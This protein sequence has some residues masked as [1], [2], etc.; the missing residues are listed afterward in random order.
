[1]MSTLRKYKYLLA[2]IIVFFFSYLFSWEHPNFKLY[3]QPPV[4]QERALD[5][6]PI[7][8]YH[9]VSPDPRAGGLGLRVKPADFDWQMR[10]LKDNGYHSVS[11]GS[12]IDH[13]TRGKKLPK[14]PFVV[15]LDD[16]YQDNYFYVYPILK[17][18]G[19]TATIFV[20]TKT[21]GRFNEFDYKDGI[22]PK[23]KMLTWDEIKEMSANGITIGAH[24][25]DHVHLTEI[26]PDKARHQIAGSKEVLEKEL[27]KE[28]QYFCYPYGEYNQAIAEIVKDSG[29]LAALTTQQGLVRPTMNPYLLKRIRILGNFDHQRF[30]NELHRF[31]HAN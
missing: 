7:L 2:A 8:A 15:T 29:Y 24:T 19:Y 11:I 5:G 21:I 6:V 31:D 1:M 9:K 22:Q 12:V 3:D 28:I 18:Y 27:K 4:K 25:I 16:G 30:I 10:Y 26:T 20:A 17:K 14:K 13:F 23:N